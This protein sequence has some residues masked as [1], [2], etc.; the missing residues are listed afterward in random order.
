MAD[1]DIRFSNISLT[2]LRK[3]PP[4][5][6]EMRLVFR[7][8]SRRFLSV[9]HNGLQRR[10]LCSPSVGGRSVPNGLTPTSIITGVPE[11]V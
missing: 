8:Q 2:T 3:S 11:A 1:N 4:L 6:P 9:R 10:V 5:V 7:S